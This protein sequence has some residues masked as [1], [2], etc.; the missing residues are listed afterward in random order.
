MH[1]IKKLSHVKHTLYKK[2]KEFSLDINN[3][4]EFLAL[5]KEYSD[6]CEKIFISKILFVEIALLRLSNLFVLTSVTMTLD[7]ACLV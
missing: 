1:Y 3:L 7:E 6:L 2:I 5:N 4:D